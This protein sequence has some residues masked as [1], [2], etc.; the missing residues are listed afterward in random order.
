MKE[1]SKKNRG[2]IYVS[3]EEVKVCQCNCHIG[4]V[5]LLQA[6]N[7]EFQMKFSGT[8]LD[9]KDLFGTEQASRAL[10]PIDIWLQGSLTPF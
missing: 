9:K 10:Q 1:G 4:H 7:G 3:A 8:K 6:A 2:A 5:A